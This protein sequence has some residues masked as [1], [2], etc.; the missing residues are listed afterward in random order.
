MARE[1]QRELI[2]FGEAYLRWAAC[3]EAAAAGNRTEEEEE[4]L[5][6]A[7][8]DAASRYAPI[9]QA[10]SKG[11]D[12]DEERAAHEALRDYYDLVLERA[13]SRG[14]G[15]VALVV[16]AV[17]I[18]R[19]WTG[20][21]PEDNLGAAVASVSW[22]GVPAVVAGGVAWSMRHLRIDGERWR[23][24]FVTPR[25]TRGRFLEFI[26]DHIFCSLANPFSGTALVIGIGVFILEPADMTGYV[27]GALVAQFIPWGRV[28][29]AVRRELARPV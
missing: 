25:D 24:V 29:R 11:T 16:T 19:L 26:R 12:E 21:L 8:W 15:A 28:W 7:L 4:A 14:A 20:S 9:A 10:A 2:E 18:L 6:E 1:H 17:V 13:A 22:W 27:V 3:V 5:H 23:T